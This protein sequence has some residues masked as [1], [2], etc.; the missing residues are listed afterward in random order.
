MQKAS[1]VSLKQNKNKSKWAT[2]ERAHDQS[3]MH[4]KICTRNSVGTY[5]LFAG[6]QKP[7]CLFYGWGGRRRPEG[8]TLHTLVVSHPPAIVVII[9]R[10][11]EFGSTQEKKK[12]KVTSTRTRTVL[13]TLTVSYV[14]CL[15][16]WARIFVKLVQRAPVRASP[17]AR[18]PQPGIFVCEFDV[19][20]VVVVV[21]LA[22]S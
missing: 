18:Q 17:L 15:S 2:Q 12:K 19:V 14:R 4:I 21:L 5:V 20:L 16:D 13:P 11:C 10:W 9:Q 1:R 3:E 7:Y 22:T 8:E 6:K